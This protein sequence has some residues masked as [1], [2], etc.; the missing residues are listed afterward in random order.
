MSSQNRSTFNRRFRTRVLLPGAMILLITAV[1][2]GGVLVAAGRG[3]DTMSM[4]GQQSEIYRAIAAGLD[5]LTLAQESVGLCDACIREADSGA[6]DPAW[7]DENIGFRL[8]DLHNVDETYILKRP[9]PAD[10]RIG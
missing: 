2:C 10:L 3:T 1:L 5:D 6:S 8:F 4:L 9:G 7:L